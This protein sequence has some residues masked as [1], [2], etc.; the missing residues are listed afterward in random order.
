MKGT[1]AQ[2]ANHFDF[3]VLKQTKKWCYKIKQCISLEEQTLT[4]FLVGGSRGT[5]RVPLEPPTRNKSRFLFLVQNKLLFF[6][7]LLV[8]LVGWL[9]C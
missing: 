5:L 1:A 3:F 9:N 8:V 2:S 7:F 6:C 4:L